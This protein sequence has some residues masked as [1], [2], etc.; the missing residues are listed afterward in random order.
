MKQKKEDKKELYVIMYLFFTLFLLLAAFF[1]YFL[2]FKSKTVINNPYNTR[3]ENFAK[4]IVRG[5]ILSNNNE[6]LAE[7][8]ESEGKEIRYYPYGNLFSH[9]VGYTDYGKAGIEQVAN[10]QLLTS[11]ISVIEKMLHDFSG[12]KDNGNKIITT[13]DLELQNIAYKALGNRQG[14]VVVME[15]S[16]GKILAMVS[17]PDFDPNKISEIL[18]ETDTEN[19][20][21]TFLLNRVTQGL[22]PPASTF[23]ILTALEY[24]REK[25]DSYGS[26]LYTC[27]GIL[28]SGEYS[29][30]CYNGKAHGE[31]DIREAFSKSCN[32]AFASMGLSLDLDYFK[33]T[34]ESLL[35]NKELPLSISY[36]KS[37]FSLSSLDSDW[38]ILQS[39]IGQGKTM[40]TPIHNALLMAAVANN[41]TLMKPYLIDRI[42][43]D[44]NDLVEKKLP[45]TYGQFISVEEAKVLTDYMQACVE[46]GTGYG[47][48]GKSYS[49]AGK[50]GTAEYGKNSKP[51]AWFVGFAPVLNPQIVVSIIVENS[52]TGSEFAVPI[53]EDIMD[54]YLK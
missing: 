3:Q 13:L 54:A 38:D 4:E 40:I 39:S 21:E 20:E 16:T 6:I 14:A 26:F 48:K 25:P 24:I 47:L 45:E 30:R 31:V 36:K 29:I 9:V 7:T 37:S 12:L 33:H 2:F 17:K 32:G 43:N 50:T 10:F 15:P 1:T 22:Y 27:D 51:H 44:Y 52:G 49:A 19:A 11:D 28:E 42:E 18:S 23:K 35:F 53:A 34:S 5:P 41:G 8:V 46:E